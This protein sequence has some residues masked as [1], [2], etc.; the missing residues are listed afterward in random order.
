MESRRS[1][2]YGYLG[3]TGYGSSYR[4]KPIGLNSGMGLSSSTRSSA[5]TSSPHPLMPSTSYETTLSAGKGYTVRH[6]PTSLTSLRSGSLRSGYSSSSSKYDAAY[7]SIPTAYPAS[8][9]SPLYTPE[10]SR[11]RYTPSTT[12]TPTP[13]RRTSLNSVS[14]ST[15]V[16]GVTASAA[17]NPGGGSYSFWDW[18][19]KRGDNFRI[20]RSYQDTQYGA[21]KSLSSGSVPS[22]DSGHHRRGNLSSHKSGSFFTL[23]EDKENDLNFDEVEEDQSITNSSYGSKAKRLS[24]SNVCDQEG[25]SG[26]IFTHIH[27][28]GIG[29]NHSNVLTERHDFNTEGRPKNDKFYDKY[30]GRNDIQS[31]DALQDTHLVM[32]VK[33]KKQDPYGKACKSASSDLDSVSGDAKCNHAPIDMKPTLQ[34]QLSFPN[35]YYQATLNYPS[36]GSTGVASSIH[37]PEEVSY[38]RKNS[39]SFSQQSVKDIHQYHFHALFEGSRYPKRRN[40][41]A[42]S[43]HLSLWYHERERQKPAESKEQ[44]LKDEKKD[45]HQRGAYSIDDRYGDS[46]FGKYY[47]QRNWYSSSL[48]HGSEVT[49]KTNFVVSPVSEWNGNSVSNC[50]SSEKLKPIASEVSG[51]TPIKEKRRKQRSKSRPLSSGSKTPCNE[52]ATHG[53]NMNGEVQ[54]QADKPEESDR[55]KSRKEIQGLIDKYTQWKEEYLYGKIHKA[56]LEGPSEVSELKPPPQSE[57]QLSPKY[58]HYITGKFDEEVPA[59]LPPLNIPPP[60]IPSVPMDSSRAPSIEDDDDGH[61][62]YRIG[63]VL[64]ERYKVLATLGEGTFGKVVRVKDLHTDRVVAIKI[65]KNVEKY[66][67]AAKLEINVLE[68]LT[69]K[70]PEGNHLC[71]KML[72]W[73]DYHGHMCL[74][75][76]I[77]GLSVFD[78]LKDNQYQ[79]YPM[80]QV[81]HISYQ[82]CYAVKFLHDNKLTHTDL[83]PENILFVDSDYE[84]SYSSKK[85]REYR[86]V[87]NTD[88]K[89]IDFGSATFDHEHHSTVVSTRH[90]RSP[91][92]LLELGWSQPCD[93]WSVGCILFELYLGITLF[94]THDNREHLAMMEHILGPIPYRAAKKTR[95]KYFHHG[96]LDFDERS[97]GARYVRDNCKPLRKYQLNDDD[98]TNQLFDLIS[99]MLDYDP[100]TRLSLGD[101]LKHPFFDKILPEK[102]LGE[103][104]KRFNCE[105][106]AQRESRSHSLSR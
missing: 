59:D 86:R 74:V 9:Y 90:Y 67:E 49:S 62:I 36:T 58:M 89:L 99:R 105:G 80:E 75:F 35:S 42:L 14:S 21:Q 19:S 92:V 45:H 38:P 27:S 98:D 81:R 65:I 2:E 15:G 28:H 31:H 91:E 1:G 100:Q 93:V 34:K 103:D 68:T 101:A 97:S 52:I 50:G 53:L 40:T 30:D 96:K 13:S 5:T 37:R 26:S 77:L 76:E 43:D 83:K 71:V 29:K 87:K 72:G 64:Q 57:Y 32:E 23:K 6:F 11:S 61:L 88:V 4:A 7:R 106:D 63:D 56:E 24:K 39:E 73:F 8:D 60:L 94:Q 95:T 54:K 85:K 84:I 20:G 102:R 25:T 82:L 41:F 18:Y 78:F 16:S 33:S 79:P 22:G 69:K 12:P 104:R 66:R 3:H 48:G 44:S 10:Y 51:S 17:T 70:D 55:D 47:N 46:W